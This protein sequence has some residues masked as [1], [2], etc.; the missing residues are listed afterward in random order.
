M[1]RMF[2]V[3]ILVNVLKFLS[4]INTVDDMDTFL[5]VIFNMD[6]LWQSSCLV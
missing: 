6:E 5:N 1:S 3:H 4:R 2:H